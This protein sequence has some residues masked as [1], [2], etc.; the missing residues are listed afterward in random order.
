MP[1]RNGEAANLAAL[2]GRLNHDELIVRVDQLGL[3]LSSA[4]GTGETC[5]DA[6]LWHRHAIQERDQSLRVDDIRTSAQFRKWPP[7]VLLNNEPLAVS[8]NRRR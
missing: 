5:L 7:A 4:D 2:L 6:L 3:R 1:A 8:P